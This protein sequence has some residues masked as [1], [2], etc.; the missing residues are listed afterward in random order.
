MEEQIK[1]LLSL[2]RQHYEN[3]DF[4]KAEE[5]LK[6]VNERDPARYADV[7][8]MLG[9]IHHDRGRF[10]EAQG[11]FEE[12]LSVNPNYTEAALNLAVTYNDLGRYDE[13]KKIYRAALSHGE[14]SPGQLDPFVK[15]KIANLHAEVAQAYMDASMTTEAI[16]ELRKA[17][18]LCPTFADLRLRLSNLYRQQGDLD[19]ARFELEE[20]LHAKP[21][22]VPGHVA[23][24][25]V[26]LSQNDKEG[27][28]KCWDAALRLDPDNRAASMYI[29]MA[30]K[31][32]ASGSIPPGAMSTPPPADSS[33]DDDV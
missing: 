28:V 6:Q 9:V 27:A 29:R 30:E 24:G 2:G 22:Y 1:Q 5:Y 12:A 14:E 20:G 18:L 11:C 26:R 33:S 21:Q 7:L 31:M 13:A 10:S 23:L 25:V 3:R 8:N 17:V 15:G 4:Q 19:A 32:L 16:H